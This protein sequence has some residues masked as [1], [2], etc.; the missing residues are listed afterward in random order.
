MHEHAEHPDDETERVHPAPVGYV[1]PHEPT[2]SDAETAVVETHPW[3]WETHPAKARIWGVYNEDAGWW[4]YKY[5]T[6]DGS[7]GVK[8]WHYEAVEAVTVR[9]RYTP[10]AA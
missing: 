3:E 4:E 10:K 5:R 8:D 2:G 9:L 1:D 7:S 6:P